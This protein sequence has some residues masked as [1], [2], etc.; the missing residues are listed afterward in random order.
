MR[1]DCDDIVVALS[2][3]EYF[4]AVRQS[5]VTQRP[6]LVGGT[7]EGQREN[8]GFEFQRYDAGVG[9]GQDFGVAGEIDSE[10]VACVDDETSAQDE[11]QNYRVIGPCHVELMGCRSRRRGGRVRRRLCWWFCW[12][13]R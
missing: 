11:T 9:N 8:H 7:G 6:V 10:A 4:P 12:C 2:G 13:S 5:K 3:G 1:V